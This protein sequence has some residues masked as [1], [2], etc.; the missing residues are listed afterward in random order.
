MYSA[1]LLG[2][3]LV[4]APVAG[5]SWQGKDKEIKKG[6]AVTVRGC[7][8][9]SALE[10]TDIERKDGATAIAAGRTF[11]LTGDKKLLKQLRD[12]H[13]G[14][15]VSVEGVLKSDLRTDAAGQ[16]ANVG[17]VRV[18]IGAQSSQPGRP[19]SESQ[20]SLPVLDVKSFEGG[21]TTSCSH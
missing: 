19:D 3:A 4:I 10:A 11:R 6:D 2:L 20:R 1:A 9:G 17:R 5:A 7:L 18:G 14:K 16:T 12:E 13:A 8:T 15:V 21:A